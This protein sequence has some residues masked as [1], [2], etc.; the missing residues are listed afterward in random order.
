[1]AE[2]NQ[3]LNALAG[4]GAGVQGQGPQFLQ[5]LR[6]QQ[7][8]SA[9]AQLSQQVQSGQ[10][11]P[12][13]ALTQMATIDPQYQPSALNY[14]L[15]QQKLQQEAPLQALDMQLKQSQIYKNLRPEE[16]KP[17]S[18]AAKLKADLD[19]GLITPQTYDAAIRK[20][21]GGSPTGINIK[22]EGALRKEFEGLSKDFRTVRDAYGR[23]EAAA[24]KPSAAGDLS[25][26]FNYMKLLD[27]G[28]TVREGEFANAQNAT[29]VPDQVAN[30]YN[31]AINGQRLNDVQRNDFTSQA[32][33]L[34]DAQAKSYNET[35][36]QYRGIAEEYGFSPDR[37]AKPYAMPS[38]PIAQYS[39]EELLAIAKR[40]KK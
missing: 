6:Q 10:L 25:L 12:Q 13:D 22:D 1:M 29:G 27:P 36:N 39:D 15:G 40:G 16:V 21:T 23:L 37:I 7:Q 34:L 2:L 14:M 17:Q 9:L 35:V 19:A 8:Q 5:G 28:S 26:I 38:R 30:M 11:A 18:T 4:F 24:A 32:R 33:G 20:A 31:R 3:F